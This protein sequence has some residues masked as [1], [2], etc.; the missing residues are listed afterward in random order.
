MGKWWFGLAFVI[1]ATVAACDGGGKPGGGSSEFRLIEFLENEQNNIARNRELVFLFSAPVKPSQDFFQRLK[2]QSVET[3]NG[4]D[5]TLAIGSYIINAERVSFQPRLPNLA[6]RMDAGFRS[7][8]NYDVFLKGGPDAL[9]S[10]GGDRIARP[11]EFRFITNEYFEDIVPS[12]PPR[13]LGFYA[14][15]ILTGA[16]SDVSRLDP[17]PTELAL[18]D[19]N[20]LLTAGRY[21]DPGTGTN[22]ATPWQ[23]ELL[24][25]EPIDP[26]TVNTEMVEMTEIFADVTTSG[27]TAAP[28][29]PDG[30]Y[31][32][33]VSFKVPAKVRVD[34]SLNQQGQIETRIIVTPVFTLVD[35]TRYRIRFNGGILGLDFRKEFIGENGLTG[36]GETIITGTIPYPEP[37]GLGYTTEFIVC[38]RAEITQ[39]RVLTYDPLVDGVKPELGQTVLDE[40]RYNSALYN[41]GSSPGTAV[42]FLSAF[43]QGT[44]G[45]LAVSGGNTVTIDTGDTPNPPIGTL[46]VLDLNPNNDYLTNTLPGGLINYDLPEPFD[47][48]LE[49]LT[50][51]SGSTLRIIGVNPIVIRCQGISEIAGTIDLSGGDGGQGGGSIAAGGDPG[52]GGFEGGSTIRGSGSCTTCPGGCNDYSTYLNQCGP[53]QASWPFN[54]NGEGPGRGYAGGAVY[55][56][57]YTND[58]TTMGGTGGGGG[59]HATKGVTGE[60]RKNTGVGPGSGGNCNDT[61]GI[62]NSGVVGVR[63]ESGPVYGDRQCAD[64]LLG[65]SGGGGGG[66]VANWNSP[67]TQAGGGGGG[68]GGS[69]SIVSAGPI[70]VSGGV[71]DASGGAGGRGMIVVQSS[72]NSWQSTSGGGGGGAGGLISL[73]SGDAINVTNALL[74]ARGGAGGV[75]SDSGT[76]FSCNSCN[77]G[78]AGGKGFIFLMDSDG[79][80]AGLLPGLPGNYDNY[81]NGVLTIS[82]FDT[83]RF[84]SIAAVTELF[85]VLSANPRYQPL[86]GGTNGDIAGWVNPD[87]R[88]RIYASSCKANAEDPLNPDITT[89]IPEVEVALLRH[90]LGATTVDIGPVSMSALNPT[91][92][93]ARDSYVR[94]DARFEYDDGVEAALGPFAWIDRVVI[95]FSLNG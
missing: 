59:S 64:I 11:Q 63:G 44:D 70:L 75:R 16:T 21:I 22:F 60:D 27:P 17:R 48:N 45:N 18:L 23:F 89:E 49:S 19:C 26:A 85:P 15:D 12:Q 76:S 81:S 35:N 40:S 61:C 88:I 2:I 5:F 73:I 56:Y 90:E 95:T 30:W 14:R 13:V 78:G 77:A 37:G 10:V 54:V 50:V 24:I 65:G 47:L 53:A 92:T 42:G 1:I 69:I 58:L 6:D 84:S 52:A 67:K 46:S 82:Q 68:G 3:G 86:V 38:D 33:P 55:T 39:T 28:S 93:P 79:T 80:I 74:D 83:T 91:G 62:R 29:A 8:S 57:D 72:A 4:S 9:E 51:S 20:D 43:G 71:I 94:I 87:Q 36:D 7:D 41:P 31:G 32:T 66:S 34:H 25:S